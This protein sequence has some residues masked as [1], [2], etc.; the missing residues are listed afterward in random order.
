MKK[1]NYYFSTTD[2][3]ELW[4]N[5]WIPDNADAAKGVILFHHGMEEYTN[6]YEELGTFLAD[7]G[8]VFNAYDCRGHGFTAKKAEEKGTGM[9]GKLADKNG[10]NI[11][12]EDL[13]EIT[14][15]AKN[16]FPGK[17][18]FL[19]GYSF[20]SFVAQ[21]FIEKYGT[22]IDGC[23]LCGT[24]GPDQFINW[25]STILGHIVCLF[26]R[27]VMARKL[28]QVPYPMY[29]KPIPKP[30]ENHLVWMATDQSVVRGYIEDEYCS[31]G[32]TRSF[33]LDFMSGCYH[34]HQ[35]K[36]MR[37]IPVNLPIFF[38]YGNEDPVGGYGKTVRKLMAIYKKN[39]VK[40]ISE[41]I[42][43]GCRHEILKDVKKEE[44]RKDIIEWIENLK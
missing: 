32:F 27:N 23:I 2:E 34:M 9:F 10:F 11:A 29:L 31:L 19:L 33:F 36:N 18:V 24:K 30:H 37:K 12:I 14:N 40:N 6:R 5:R 38:I 21:G 41:K 25:I 39:G 42:Y 8:Y 16:R 4:I 26:G 43:E 28:E 15:E 22:E 3:T 1:E 20:G 13:L 17:K 35:K 7:N 44:V